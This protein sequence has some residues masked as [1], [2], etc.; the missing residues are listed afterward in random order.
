VLVDHDCICLSNVNRQIHATRR[1]VGQVKVEAMKARMLEINPEVQVEAIRDFYNPGRADELIGEGFDYILDCIDTV[2]G[3]LDLIQ[4]AKRR[5]IPIISA[6]GAGNKLDPTGFEV[7]DLSKT[8]NCPLAK[9]MRKELRK[10]G[11]RHLKVVYSQEE[12]LVP[13]QGTD[14]GCPEDCDCSK[15][16]EPAI[17]SRRQLPGSVSFVPGVVGMIM[18]GEVIKDLIRKGA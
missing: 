1:T 12:A 18:A 11:I 4:E 6:M 16:G 3:K 14:P 2:T 9:I 7:T 8:L 10:R 13:D 17:S 15:K 5:E